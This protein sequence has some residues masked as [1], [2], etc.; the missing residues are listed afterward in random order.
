MRWRTMLGSGVF[1]GTQPRKRLDQTLGVGTRTEIAIAVSHSAS[2]SVGSG[3]VDRWKAAPC[4]QRLLPHLVQR[5]VWA[6]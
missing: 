2:D 1:A 3:A 6:Y 4:R 5:E